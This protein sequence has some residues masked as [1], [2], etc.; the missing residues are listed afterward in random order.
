LSVDTKEE[1]EAAA[2][3]MRN[4]VQLEVPLKVDVEIGTTWGSAE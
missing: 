2:E 1:A 3:I 4:C